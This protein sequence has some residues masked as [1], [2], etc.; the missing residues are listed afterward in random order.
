MTIVNSKG[1]DS[2]VHAKVKVRNTQET[3]FWTFKFKG[4]DY[5]TLNDGLA[6]RVP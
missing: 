5:I 3:N 2:K 1:F 6:V 4:L